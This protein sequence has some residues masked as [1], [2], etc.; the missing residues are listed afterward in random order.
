MADQGHSA[1][2]GPRSFTRFIE[3]L[4]DGQAN[5]DLSNELF[6]LGAVLRRESVERGECRGELQLTLKFKVDQFG[7]VIT[8]YQIKIKEPEPGRPASMFWL[9]KHGNFSVDNPRQQS[10]PLHEVV[11]QDGEVIEVGGQRPAREV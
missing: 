11:T 10:L 1:G 8:S 7:Q 2:E 5:S 4:G 9:T 6:D 3:A